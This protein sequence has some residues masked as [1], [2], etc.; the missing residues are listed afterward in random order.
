V[1]QSLFSADFIASGVNSDV[2]EVAPGQILVAR[3][4]AHEAEKTKS[5]DEVKTQVQA[6]VLS[7]KTEELAQAKALELVAE[8]QNGKTFAEVAQQNGLTLET[9]LAV[10]RFGADVDASIRSK[11][12]ELARPSEQAPVTYGSLNT[13]SGDAAVLAVTKVTDVETVPAPS[14]EELQQYGSQKSQQSYS[15][16]LAALKAKAKIVRSLDGLAATE[17]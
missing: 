8:L 15:A 5:F 3:V 10:T 17:E 2:L 16:V 14:K 12:F 13:S 11:A 4:T 9:K 1:L 6:A 7:Q